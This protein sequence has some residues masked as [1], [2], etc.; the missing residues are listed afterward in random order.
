[1]ET[2]HL[3]HDISVFCVTAFSFPA[4]IEHAFDAL[5]KQL[6]DAGERIYF[7]LSYPDKGTIVYKAAVQETEQGEAEKYGCERFVIQKGDYVS[8]KLEQWEKNIPMIGNIFQELIH[9][10]PDLVAPCIEWYQGKDV[11][12]LVRIEK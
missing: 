11:L 3:D 12:C 7:G 2:Y 10:R 1:M 9:S 8:R 5:K 4:G 6:P